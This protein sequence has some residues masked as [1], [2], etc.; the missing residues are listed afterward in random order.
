MSISIVIPLLLDEY[1]LL[2]VDPLL[3]TVC[4]L[5]AAREPIWEPD[6]RRKMKDAYTAVI[7]AEVQT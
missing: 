3:Y 6:Q 2:V 7:R 5:N 1:V 4:M